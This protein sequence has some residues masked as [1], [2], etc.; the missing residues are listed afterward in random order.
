MPLFPGVVLL[1]VGESRDLCVLDS[2]VQYGP[3]RH[4]YNI[5]S[6]FLYKAHNGSERNS[7]KAPA[8]AIHY[9]QNARLC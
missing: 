2:I 4:T 6:A 3:N 8:S 5:S 1:L 9:C 7:C